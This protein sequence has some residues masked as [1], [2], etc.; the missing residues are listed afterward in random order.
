MPIF[1][2]QCRACSHSFEVLQK[3]GAAA[4]T[5]CPECSK[6]ELR[7]LLSAP[8]FHLKGSGWRKTDADAS[9]KK[10]KARP[11]FAHTFDSPT[12]HAEHHDHDDSHSHSHGPG[13]DHGH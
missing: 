8:N 5:E 7:K 12:P 6:P 10:P 9:R 4:L 2:Y 11:K 13:H 1:D 3:M